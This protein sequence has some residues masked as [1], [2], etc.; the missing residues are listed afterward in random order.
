MF[1]NKYIKYIK[2]MKK[3]LSFVLLATL[4]LAIS[5]FKSKETIKSNFLTPRS[6]SLVSLKFEKKLNVTERD[7]AM[8]PKRDYCEAACTVAPNDS[9]GRAGTKCIEVPGNCKSVRPCEAISGQTNL[10]PTLAMC[11][12]MAMGHANWMYANGYIDSVDIPES[13]DIAYSSLIAFWGL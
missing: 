7:N 6:L 10:A 2:Y 13:H 1:E 4:F 11:E 8:I 12:T 5:A 3:K 9:T